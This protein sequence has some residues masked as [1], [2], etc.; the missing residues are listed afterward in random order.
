MGSMIGTSV[1]RKEDPKLL[2]GRGTYVDDLALPGAVHMAFVRSHVASGAIVGVDPSVARS[3]TGVLGVWTAA[4]LP[5]IPGLPT[6]PG[7]VRPCLASGVVRFVGEPVAVVVAVS[8]YLAAD[9]AAD[10]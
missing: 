4:D 9:A 6:V 10:V 3:R 2:A 8:R 1:A 5:E 7:M